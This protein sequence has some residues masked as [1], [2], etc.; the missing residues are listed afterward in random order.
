MF[1]ITG[2]Y[3]N[4]PTPGNPGQTGGIQLSGG[5]G[6]LGNPNYPC[7]AG[8]EILPMSSITVPVD[9]GT[10]YDFHHYLNQS[11]IGMQRGEATAQFAPAT[12]RQQHT[13][14]FDLYKYGNEL[15]NDEVTTV[16]LPLRRAD[17]GA[18]AVVSGVGTALEALSAPGGTSVILD[19]S[20]ANAY[21]LLWFDP[22][23]LTVNWGAGRVVRIGLRWMAWKDD[24]A[25]ATPGEGFTVSEW[26]T[27]VSASGVPYASWLVNNYQR[28]SQ[29]VTR[30]LGETNYLAPN[31]M[32][33]TEHNKEPFTVVDLTRMG[34]AS[35]T[36]F[37][38]LLGEQGF[39]S[40]QTTTYLDYI[41]MIV[42][43][44]PERRI[45]VGNR[46]ISNVLV[47]SSI[48]ADYGYD[49]NYFV[50]WRY[51]PNTASLVQLTSTR[52]TLC[53]REAIP[54]DSSDRYRAY[55]DGFF[56]WTWLEAIGPSM[57]LMGVAQ[58]RQTQDPQIETFIGTISD[59]VLVGTP[60][61]FEDYNLG[62]AH[63]DS[64]DFANSGAFWA[65]YASMGSLYELS[66]YSGASDF[67]RVQVDGMT[68]YTRVKLFAQP[69]ELTQDDLVVSVSNVTTGALFASVAVS[70]ATVRALPDVGNGW[71]EFE[72]ILDVPVTPP[73]G[74]VAV[75]LSS[76]TPS[77]APWFVAAARP[78]GSEQGQMR[79]GYFYDT[80]TEDIAAVLVCEPVVPP[81]PVASITEGSLV[82]SAACGIESMGYY[83]LTWDTEATTARY[84]VQRRLTGE[85]DW[86]TIAIVDNTYPIGEIYYD[87]AAPWDVSIDYRIG[88][89]RDSDQVITYGPVTLAGAIAS[90]GAAL[91]ISDTDNNV[92]VYVPTV[93]AGS[94]STGWNDLNKT[95]L[96]QLLGEDFN[97]ALQ[98]PDDRGMS[99]STQVLIA[100]LF[101]C[102]GGTLNPLTVG[103]RSM[104]PEP[105]DLLR[106]FARQPYVN[107]RF[108]GGMVRQ[109]VLQL[110][111]LT[112]R[113]QFGVYLAEIVLTDAYVP[114]LDITEES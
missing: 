47:D 103:Q 24:S 57:Q 110:G 58:S 41:E 94:L 35:Q 6:I 28:D 27:S 43:V 2:G 102:T 63:Y 85:T 51:A 17:L 87:L 100:D 109:M 7:I 25:T 37:W 112:V 88:S 23:E 66:V 96:V 36:M 105:Y 91:G 92:M 83:T 9:L 89:Y 76:T 53:V 14:A 113:N 3:I 29:Y 98:S 60:Q 104:S 21:V 106:A 16:I 80:N 67:V 69:D 44:V 99:F 61:P 82:A 108:P 84:E 54:A 68:T 40:S 5:G 97:R 78:L 86:T 71:R 59:G 4:N 18:G 55:T 42:E 75:T 31:G 93:D 114:G 11:S 33:S 38:Q 72:L 79:F 52:Y 12:Q 49:W 22:T 50:Q 70:P 26:D 81:A 111:N 13:I 77:V 101:A 8:A 62:V 65:S 1:G 34:A 32:L 46:I 15:T 56:R 64:L 74:I 73:S 30:W 48:G 19:G 10:R 95:E 107:V 39:D 45:A 20:A 90:Q